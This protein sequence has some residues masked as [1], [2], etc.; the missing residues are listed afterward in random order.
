M[1]TKIR[2]VIRGS[3]VNHDG[4]KDGITMP[5][6][7]AQE[8]LIRKTYKNAGLSTNDTQYFE[9]HGTGT[10]DGDPRET[11][12][13]GAVFAPNRPEPLHVGSVKT[14]IRHLE[15]A[16]GLA[17]I[18]ETTLALKA[19]KIPPNM[20]FNNPNPNIDFENWKIAV[21]TKA[22]DWKLSHGCRRASINSFGYGG[23]NAHAIIEGYTAPAGEQEISLPRGL[24]AMVEKRPFLLP[25]TSHTEKAGNLFKAGLSHFLE[26]NTEHSA[27]ALARSLSEHGRTMHKVRSFLVEKDREDTLSGLHEFLTWTK[28]DKSKTRIGFVFTGQGAQSF[29][30]GRQL[31]EQSPFF[32]QTLEKCDDV[33]Q[34]LPDRPDWSCVTELLKTKEASRVTQSAFSQPLCTA[35]QIALVDLLAEWGIQPSVTVGHSA[36]EMGAAYA[37]G[38]LSFDDAIIAGYYRGLTLGMEVENAV[39]VPGSMLA[40]QMT[41]TEATA[42]LE[43]YKGRISLA[44]VNSP[45]SLTL[46]GELPAILELKESL[47]KRNI[48]ARQLQVDKAYC[49]HH[50]APFGPV[51]EQ[52]LSKIQPRTPRCQ[53][54]SSVTTRNAEPSKMKAAYW[55]SNL[56]GQVRFADAL[57]NLLLNDNE[58]QNV[59]MLLEIGPHPAL[60]GPAKE[61][62][63]SLK[64][65]IPYIASLNRGV[66]DFGSL[67]SCVGQLFGLGY[68]VDLAAANSN[69][70]FNHLGSVQRAMAG[71][72][73]QLPSYAWDHAKYWSET[74]V[75]KNNRL[76]KDRHVILGVPV[77]DSIDNHPRW[78]TF[79][80]PAE[81]P[82]LSQ[83]M[84]EGKVIFP[85]A[86]YISM[87]IEAA[88]R[89][90]K[91]PKAIKSVS[92]KDISFKSALP[93]RAD[94]MGT[95]VLLEIQPVLASAKR[96]SDTWYRFI[97]S[98]YDESERCDDTVMASFPLTKGCLLRLRALNHAR[99]LRNFRR[100][101]T[102]PRRC[103]STMTISTHWVYS[104][105]KTS[106]FS[107]ATLSLHLASPW[108][109]SPSVQTKSAQPQV[110]FALCTPL[111][112][113][114][115]SMSSLQV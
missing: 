29:A 112:W 43:P 23:T 4:A 61:L 65:E 49:S 37:A 62:M 28:S 82:W 39:K 3:D 100:Y 13:I 30:M 109:Q 80:R 45:T 55:V 33:L 19:H 51:L 104:T 1:A 81:L 42:E 101:P 76:R 95:E 10:Q 66:P 102:E 35:I 22:L 12:A 41:E 75:I 15:G 44:A 96:T 93:V 97:I 99:H 17:G 63:K 56:T 2:S 83:H 47:S 71:P 64:L 40:V 38:I 114:L 103:K 92:L 7:K 59:D 115:P 18:I 74:R 67:L 106:G 58:E 68:P 84:I 88:T 20:L 77:A 78:R 73:V 21:P 94:D 69:L 89:L 111:S 5:N 31:I 90:E 6:S 14:N 52:L 91:C 34:S 25:L 70:F 32:R 16:S 113:T 26:D 57:T 72:K 48:F 8:N 50:I 36:G 87:A 46:S 79:L 24:A 86:G 9:A 105:E 108:H 85:A 54:S 60:R 98:S 53:M 110:T 11:R 107:R 27:A